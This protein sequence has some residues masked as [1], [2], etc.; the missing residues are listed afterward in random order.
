M[1]RSHATDSHAKQVYITQIY[2]QANREEYLANDSILHDN[3]DNIQPRETNHVKSNDIQWWI[4][5]CEVIKTKHGK[6]RMTM[7]SKARWSINIISMSM[8][9]TNMAMK[10]RKIKILNQDNQSHNQ[11]VKYLIQIY[12]WSIK[13]LVI[14]ESLTK[15]INQHDQPIWSTCQCPKWKLGNSRRAIKRWVPTDRFTKCHV[16]FTLSSSLTL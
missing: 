15:I 10:H 7:L 4:Y 8:Y 5:T 3:Q 14:L 13:K 1:R 12:Q 6:I 9:S 2:T 16:C 11:H